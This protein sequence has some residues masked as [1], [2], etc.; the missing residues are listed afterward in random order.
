MRMRPG[1]EVVRHIGA[2]R[3]GQVTSVKNG[4]CQV[5]W[6]GDRREWLAQSD[7]LWRGLTIHTVDGRPGKVIELGARRTRV[8]LGNGVC[9]WM[10]PD[11]IAPR[12][13][14]PDITIEYSKEGI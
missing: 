1:L 12:E 14:Q 4:L 10:R 11:E 2:P 6:R 7:L 13:S 5:L 3:R 9:C 8:R